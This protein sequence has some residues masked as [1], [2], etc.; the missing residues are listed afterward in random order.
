MTDLA[1]VADILAKTT[2]ANRWLRGGMYLL[3]SAAGVT[4]LF[5]DLPFLDN[6]VNFTIL[7]L[8]LFFILGGVVSGVGHF[9]QILVVER[10]GYP[11]LLAALVA[12]TVILFIEAD[13]NVARA[14]IGLITLAFALGL[15]G[16]SRDLGTLLRIQRSLHQERVEHGSE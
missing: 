5:L 12:L 9:L 6:V 4:S 1:A 8:G 7:M 15:Y 3:L 14:F 11:L 16:R 13:E 10:A 2:Q